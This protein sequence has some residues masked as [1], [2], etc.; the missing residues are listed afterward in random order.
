MA[1]DCQKVIWLNW[2][3]AFATRLDRQ[4]RVVQ[5]GQQLLA[6]AVDRDHP[7]ELPPADPRLR[8]PAQQGRLST[9]EIIRCLKRY[10]ARE[11]NRHLR[12]GAG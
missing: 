6:G 8:C 9:K 10:V 4:R 2:D 11:V 1:N 3:S 7:D 5:R 12:P